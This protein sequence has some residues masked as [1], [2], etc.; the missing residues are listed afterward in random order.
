VTTGRSE[1]RLTAT[2]TDLS[3]VRQQAFLVGSIFDH[4]P[5]RSLDELARLAD[6]A[7]SDPVGRAVLRARQPNPA[8]LIGSGQA[9]ELAHET[10][11]LEVDV[12]IFDDDLTPTQ[13]RNLQKVFTCDVVDRPGLILDIFAQHATSRAGM[14][15]V[16]LALLRYHLP[17]LRGRGNALS[18]QAGGIGTRGPG[19]TKLETD[20][21]RIERRIVKLGVEL[22]KLE[23]T[24][25]TQRKARA[26]NDVPLIALVGYTNAGKSTMLNALTGTDVLVEDRLFS[27]LDATVRRLE[28]PDGRGVVVSDTVG[29][30]RRIPHDLIAAFHSTLEEIADASVVVHVADAS[31]PDTEAHIAAVR[32]VLEELDAATIPEQL[33][34]NKIDAADP[35]HLRRLLELH[36]DAIATSCHTGHGFGAL[37]DRVE[38]LLPQETIETTVVVP[39]DRPDLLAAVWSNTEV[40]EE[41]HTDT[42]TRFTVRMATKLLPIFS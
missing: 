24:R 19:E 3:V 31:D 41:Y 14:L 26:R 36:Q 42:G 8:T 23:R 22:E 27:T 18:R 32:S 13:Q 6:T 9:S 25:A 2:V 39:Y 1:R 29:F 17:R 33:V 11:R 7:G 38:R 40:L 34:F 21:R 30:V 10:A 12:V 20:R 5:E 16:E 4:E 35:V 28:L 37:L 15:Q